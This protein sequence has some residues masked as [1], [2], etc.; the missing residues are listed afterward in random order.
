MTQRTAALA[1]VA[2]VAA[3]LGLG[4]AAPSRA[5]VFTI[6]PVDF[7][8]WV[9]PF[10]GSPGI[11]SQAP[12]FGAV[13]NPDF[14]DKDGQAVVAVDTANAGIQ[15]RLAPESYDVTSVKVWVTHS[16]GTF[17]YD[18]TYDAW[19]TYLDSG[20]PNHV[21]DADSGRPLEL[22]GVGFR[23]GYIR[24]ST[25]PPNPGPPLF[26]EDDP[27]GGTLGEDVRNVFALDFGVPDPEGDVSNN[28]ADGYDPTPWALGLSTS[29]L[30][31]GDPVPQGVPGVSAGETFEFTVDLADPDV[32]AY[33]REGLADGVLAFSV[34]SLQETG[35]SGGTNPSIYTSNNFDPAA[36]KP[37]IEIDVTLDTECD[38]GIDN[39]GDG[40]IDWNGGPLGEPPDPACHGK[41]HLNREGTQCDDDL[42]N[43]AVPDGQIDWDGGPLGGPA[44]T[45]C[46]GPRDVSEAP[47]IPLCGL[48]FELVLVLPL[49]MRL[50]GLRIGAAR[51]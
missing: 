21:A 26:E 33:V 16:T 40:D 23:G 35:M 15:P 4:P 27:F 11:R 10:N 47:G 31:P 8:R 18:P 12:L 5:T 37:R 41:A 1:A 20:D 6:D 2:L 28:V 24:I 51:A 29:G 39:D 38:D 17:D 46:V 43:E 3:T 7:D 42:D 30:A 44:D 22:Y 34:V 25:G 14:D 19:Q 50:R 49:L 36:V 13:G 9:Y 48:G 45:N 32:L